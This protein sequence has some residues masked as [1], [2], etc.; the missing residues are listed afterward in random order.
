MMSL[1]R[2]P[3]RVILPFLLLATA[4]MILQANGTILRRKQRTQQKSIANTGG[5][6]EPPS[7]LSRKRK[8]EGGGAV[9]YTHLTLPTILLV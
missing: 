4:A 7:P 3:T 5:L 2:R 1:R 8:R 6:D 9:S